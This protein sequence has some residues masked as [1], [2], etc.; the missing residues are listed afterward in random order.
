M[1]AKEITNQGK[2][3]YYH[4]SSIKLPVGTILRPQ[5]GY[6]ERW[7]HTDFY[8]ILEM[9]RPANMLSHAN[10][11]F[12][13]DNPDDVDLA[14]GATDWLFTVIPLGQV[15]RHDMNY[16]SE[17]SSLVSLGHDFDSEEIKEAAEDYWAGIESP[18]EVIWEYLTPAAKILKVERY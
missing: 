18:N 7:S 12:M 9:Y 11:V 6:E 2:K 17:I 4:G 3:L 8:N 1:R 16:S 13:C 5:L 15:Q 10:S 14:G